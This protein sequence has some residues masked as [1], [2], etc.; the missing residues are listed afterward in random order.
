M[1]GKK[2]KTIEITDFCPHECI[3]NIKIKRY[4]L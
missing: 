2:E 4:F 1:N 3:F